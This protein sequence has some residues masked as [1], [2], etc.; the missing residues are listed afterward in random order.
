MLCHPE[1]TF[2][3]EALRVLVLRDHKSSPEAA[4]VQRELPH[5]R[6]H[7][8]GGPHLMTDD[9]GV[10]GEVQRC[11]RT[12]RGTGNSLHKVCGCGC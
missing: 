1:S 8:C 12:V 9:T 7:P 10:H 3:T 6:L 5:P 4:L 2:K 11:N